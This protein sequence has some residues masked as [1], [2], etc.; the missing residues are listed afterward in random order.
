[1]KANSIDV[2]RLLAML[3]LD[4][5]Q[6]LQALGIEDGTI[7]L[8][9]RQAASGAESVRRLSGAD[10]WGCD[11][12]YRGQSRSDMLSVSSS[13]FDRHRIRACVAAAAHGRFWHDSDVPRCPPN[14]CCR[15]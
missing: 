12:C 9:S 8:K 10:F 7:C 11:V 13:A 3:A 14:V 15:G 1:M 6:S 4:L 2:A 5:D